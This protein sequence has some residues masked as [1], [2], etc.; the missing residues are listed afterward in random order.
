MILNCISKQWLKR[1]NKKKNIYEHCV[2]CHKKTDV[3]FDTPIQEREY[4]VL[5]CGQLCGK[6]Y[7]E[8]THNK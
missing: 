4:F 5:G 2:I 3:L 7:W 8:I 6:C 1:K